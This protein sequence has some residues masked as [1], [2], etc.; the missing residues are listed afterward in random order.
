[1]ITFR[2]PFQGEYPITQKYGEII[3]GVTFQG[4]PHS[5]IDYGCPMNT[6]VLASAGGTVIFAGADTTGYGM[7]VIILHK[8]DRATLYA[9]LSS[10]AVYTNQKVQQGDIIGYSGISGNATGPHLHFE[11]RTKWNDYRTHFDPMSLPL[12]AVDD[13][14]ETSKNFDRTSQLKGADVFNKGDLLKVQNDIGVKAF[15]D[16]DFSYDRMTTYQKGTPFYFTGDTLVRKDN[17]LTYMRV[18]PASFSIWIAVNNG[19][20]QLL[21]K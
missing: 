5:G 8:A 19:K 15:Y 7:M 6:P 20:I 11:A 2:Q 16:S 3:P 12:M 4:K 14:A 21:D 1:M 13:S 10:I 9:H 17:G 18:I